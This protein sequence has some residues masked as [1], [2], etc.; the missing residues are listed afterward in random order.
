MLS[1]LSRRF[2]YMLLI[3][4]VSSIVSFLIVQLPAGDFVDD[5][6]MQYVKRGE[7]L[8]QEQLDRLRQRYG[9]DRPPYI[10]YLRW[11]GNLLQG[12][13]GWSF[14]AQQPVERVI[15]DRLGL[16]VTISIA[17]LLFTYLMAVPIGIY[18]ATHQYSPGDYLGMFVGFLGMA[19]PNFLLAIIL[20]YVLY[21]AGMKV[22]G[23][24]SPEYM[25]AE[26]SVD[27]FVDLLK[28]LPLPVIIIGT[29]G[30]AGL[31][32]VMRASLLDEL[33]KQYVIT[34]RSK[35]LREIKLTFKYPVRVALNPIAS[36]IGWL[37]P[38]I[39][40]GSVITAMVLN[41][42]TVGPTLYG[43][44]ISEDMFLASSLLFGL[45][46]LT[47]IGTFVSDI[48]LVIVDPRIRFTGRET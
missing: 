34:A 16:T 28:H 8:E 19:M 32:R 10:Q 45:C 23:L 15:G 22:S 4:W 24:F 38:E 42:P 44:L 5:L 41:L 13:L 35:G 25:R 36:T 6:A 9:L 31:I 21:N 37:L 47:V 39:V 30:T 1:Y 40:S 11:A 48:A 29:A 18:S 2:L 14:G 26:W 7:Q 27:K 3:V 43:A 20:M 17:T 33:G 46:V 12:Y